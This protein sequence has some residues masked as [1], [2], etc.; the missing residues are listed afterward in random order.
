MAWPALIAVAK[1]VPWVA[2]VQ[3]APAILDAANRLRARSRSKADIS[4]E[5]KPA[6]SETDEIEKAIAQLQNQDRET[7]EVIR[8]LAEQ[9]QELATSIQTLAAKT[10]ALGYGLLVASLAALAAVVTVFV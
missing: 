4:E 1:A 10:R 2:L 9:N 6:R 7:A 5:S 8:Q 3:Q